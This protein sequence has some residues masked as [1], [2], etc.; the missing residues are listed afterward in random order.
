MKTWV[1]S[2]LHFG[3]KNIL[4]YSPKYRTFQDASE[5]NEAIVAGWNAKV[6]DDDLVYILGD[7]AF[8]NAEKA[9]EL[10]KRLNGRKILIEGNHDAK[11]MQN[12]EFVNC[13]EAVHKYHEITH[14]GNRVCLFHYRIFEWN[15]C[16]RGSLHLFGHAHGNGGETN[17]RSMD[18]GFDATGNIVSNLDDIV[19]EL[20]K[21][22]IKL[23]HAVQ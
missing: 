15:Q 3:H 16:H 1:S 20:S 21:K 2:D 8:C 18:V 22:E 10:V 11:L 23:H 12:S 6:N 5:M 9:C 19:N 4:K 13:F 14:N 17:N 7:V